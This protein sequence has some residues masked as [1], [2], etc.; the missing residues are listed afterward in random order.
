MCDFVVL[1]R[2]IAG[3]MIESLQNA[4]EVYRSTPGLN[5]T[6]HSDIMGDLEQLATVFSTLD[7]KLGEREWQTYFSV[8]DLRS[9]FVPL[10]M[11]TCWLPWES[12]IG[13]KGIHSS[14]GSLRHTLKPVQKPFFLK[15]IHESVLMPKHLRPFVRTP[16]PLALAFL[17][18][19]AFGRKETGHFGSLFSVQQKHSMYMMH[20]KTHQHKD[21]VYHHLL[22]TAPSTCWDPTRLS[23]RRER[24]S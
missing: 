8:E 1:T 20:H 16:R 2:G 3:T 23:C 19:V 7:K 18:E 13:S 12:P 24:R 11:E 22:A 14:P 9:S 4:S 21:T 6:M 10:D 5:D 17:H 15:L